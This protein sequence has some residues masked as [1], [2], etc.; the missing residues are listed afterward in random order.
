MSKDDSQLQL[1]ALEQVLELGHSIAQQDSQERLHEARVAH[2]HVQ[3]E[4][5]RQRT[6][7]PRR[8]SSTSNAGTSGRSPPMHTPAPRG[9]FLSGGSGAQRSHNNSFTGS[10]VLAPSGHNPAIT[11]PYTPTAQYNSHNSNIS[12]S[13]AGRTNG[14]ITRLARVPGQ[15]PDPHAKKVKKVSIQ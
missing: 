8:A 4:R 11:T 10:D 3:Q 9:G 2:A 14:A 13:S 1:R 15:T 12:S 5:R 7:S 6:P